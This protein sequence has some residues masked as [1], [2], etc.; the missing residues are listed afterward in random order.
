MH[1]TVIP[2]LRKVA[3][4]ASIGM[5]GSSIHGSKFNPGSGA[6][7]GPKFDPSK[8]D[9]DLYIVSPKLIEAIRANPDFAS[10]VQKS[11]RSRPL[12]VGADK[13]LWKKLG[14]NAF[15]DTLANQV[16]TRKFRS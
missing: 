5:R 10:A 3:P 14:L 12:S 15:A 8:S 16:P 4:N 6:Y 7:D 2:A 9:V 13:Q 11:G 1:R